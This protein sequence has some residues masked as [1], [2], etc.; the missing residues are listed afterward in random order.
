MERT[1]PP[2]FFGEW[3]RK[4]REAL[5]FTQDELAQRAACSVHTIRKIESG[6]RRPSKQLA[7]LLATSLGIPSEDHQT[8]I[9][10]ARGTINLERLPKITQELSFAPISDLQPSVPSSQLP[11]QVTPLVGRDSEMA[12]MDRLFDNPQCRLLTLTGMGGIGKTRL[13]IEFASEQEAG[14]PGGVYYVPL[15][16]INSTDAI[17]PAIADTLGL[18]F[19]GPTD[20]KEQ[21]I[22]Y[23]SFNFNKPTLL[24]LDNLE[25]LLAQ[26]SSKSKTGVDGLVSEFLQ[27][28]PNVKILATSRERLNLQG[29][30]TYEL[31]GLTVPPHEYSGRLLDCSAVTLFIKS[32]ARIKAGFELTPEE[33]PAIVKICQLLDGIPLA[34]ELAAAWVGILSCEEIAQ[35]ISLNIDFLTSTMRDIPD[36]H[37]S[38]R[39]TFE[40]SWNL[41]SDEERDALRHLSV[42]QGEFDRGSADK[43]AGAPLPLLA[44]LVSKSLV[45]RTQNNHYDLHEAIRQFAMSHLA[46]NPKHY[47]E[48]CNLHCNHYLKLVSGHEKSFRSASQQEAIGEISDSLDNI[49]AAWKW[50]V[51]QR[52]FDL[53]SQALR[54]MGWFYELA[55]LHREGF[56]LMELVIQMV[57]Q[58]TRNDRLDILMG[59]ATTQRGLLYF[60]KGQVD[61]AK[62]IYE[63]S[64]AILRPVGDQEL[65]ADAL[66]FLGIIKH[67]HGEYTESAAMV[68]EGLQ[69]AQACGDQ[70]IT[71]YAIYNLGYVDSML[72][73]YQRGYEQMQTGLDMWRAIGDLH[74]MA[75]GLNFLVSTQIKLGRYEEA[76]ASMLESI[77]L[78]EQAKNRWGMGTAYRYLGL[79]CLADGQFTEA[80][81]H[82]NKS[83]AIFS[84]YTGGWDIA[85][86]VAYLGEAIMMAGNL[87][88]A[89]SI[90]LDGLHLAMDINAVP[91]ALDSLLGL[92]QIYASRG[93]TEIALKN[94]L[95]VLNHPSATQESKDRA[96]LLSDKLAV[97]LNPQKV[98]SILKELY[99]M[100]LEDIVTEVPES[101]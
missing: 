34:I 49:R 61:K 9:K 27:R 80:E 68:R 8:F 64:V 84:G 35:E 28:L 73:D 85:I 100:E 13:A 53:I 26:P 65:L 7:D 5:D 66:V 44:S 79:A 42:F 55:G 93:K 83:I 74:Y 1:N 29:E 94:S 88:K 101:I 51:Q 63:D 78:C 24:V 81:E 98:N 92:A 21:L 77:A 16:P 39:A 22:T 95:F 54:G 87:N 91:I 6:E 14:F 17:V 43:I 2:T 72:G 82:F 41:L 76:K 69:Y 99:T 32:A 10:V 38:L 33:Q 40:H 67:L 58:E 59:L 48:V 96:G 12:S 25:H 4:R 90:F 18:V 3:V 86:S 89:E 56:E 31:H 36:R 30:W 71:A 20:P 23:L 70:W 45:R 37:R 11:I 52:N 75:L 19:S 57:I 15:T 46:E 60:R 47:N 62:E 97:Q 50:A